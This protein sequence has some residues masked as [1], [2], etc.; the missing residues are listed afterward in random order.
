MPRYQS[1]WPNSFCQ[2]DRRFRAC[3]GRFLVRDSTERL[4]SSLSRHKQSSQVVTPQ[5]LKHI[6]S[7]SLNKGQVPK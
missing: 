1:G 2:N 7:L 6:K 4:A 3:P 5:S